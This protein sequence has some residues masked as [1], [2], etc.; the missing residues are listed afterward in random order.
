MS[1]DPIF[2]RVAITA[3]LIDSERAALRRIAAGDPLRDVL[4][5]VVTTVESTARHPVRASVLLMDPDGATLRHGAAPSLPDSYNAIVDGLPIGPFQGSCG[6]AAYSGEPA[7]VSD[8]ATDPRWAAYASIAA[9][10]AMRACWSTPLIGADGMLLGTFAIYLDVPGGPTPEDLEVIVLVTQTVALTIERCRSVTALRE[11][12]DHYRHTVAHNP[13]IAWTATADGVVDQ[14]AQRWEDWTGAPGTGS[15]WQDVLHP[16]DVRPAIDHWNRSVATGEPY[17]IEYRLR[18]RS[19][20]YRWVR[21]RASARFDASGQIVKWYGSTED[22]DDRRRAEDRLRVNEAKLRRLNQILE[23]QVEDS[24]RASER[25][26][27]MSHEVLASASI[28]GYLLRVNPAFTAVLGWPEDAVIG[29]PLRDFTSSEHMAGAEPWTQV[30]AGDVPLRQDVAFRHKEGGHRWLSLTVV[31]EGDALFMFGRDIT[32]ERDAADALLIA[33][34]SLRQAQKMEALGQLTGGIAHDFNNLLQ[35]IT[36]PLE[37]IDHALRRKTNVDLSRYVAL[38]RTSAGRAAALTHRLLAFSRRQPLAPVPLN[39]NDLVDSMADLLRRTM[40]EG[41]ETRT[42]TDPDIWMAR[43]DANQLENALLNL[44]INAR[45]AMPDGGA[46]TITTSNTEL[47]ADAARRLPGVAAGQYVLIQVADTGTGMSPDIVQR[48]FEPFYTT[49]PIGQGTGLGL[50]M[51]YGFAQQ[52]GGTARIDSREGEG[53]SI[54]LY[55]PRHL[56]TAVALD[57]PQGLPLAADACAGANVLVV[58][59]DDTVRA[60]VCEVLRSLDYQ[61]S[62]AADGPSGLKILNSEAP[63]DVLLTDVGLPGLNGRQLADAALQTRPDL[64]VLFMTGYAEAATR[65]AGFLT[66]NMQMITKPFELDDLTTR[67]SAMLARRT[68]A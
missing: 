64:K 49:K 50:S 44:A 61:V 45:D 42:V 30:G 43:C 13:Q 31:S 9:D 46:L 3:S 36:G 39:P 51:A 57:D 47:T 5:S 40:G 48:A 2:H 34:E 20:S 67:L 18:L 35:G 27:T 58:E 15:S 38:A 11:S 17:D 37:L 62:E 41:I 60:V 7:Y 66:G 4:E 29:M 19:G 54:S 16:V 26:W 52:S 25:V 10:Y 28:D 63:L 6:S 59:D 55:L 68:A 23:G 56:A 21:S 1:A 14:V 24:S 33:E 32:A 53:T 22:V 12:E 65:S 8:I